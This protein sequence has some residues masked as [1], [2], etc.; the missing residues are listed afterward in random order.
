MSF[1]NCFGSR[2]HHHHHI[3]FPLS[4]KGMGWKLA[5]NYVFIESSGTNIF[6]QN[7]VFSLKGILELS[8]ETHIL[9]KLLAGFI[10]KL[11]SW[12]I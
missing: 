12:A 10:T 6:P 2:K 7:V 5:Y 8:R 9:L 4:F 1:D 3:Q 11:T